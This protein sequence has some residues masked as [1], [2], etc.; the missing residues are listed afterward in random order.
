MTKHDE[1]QKKII[2][3]KN[4][5]ELIYYRHFITSYMDSGNEKTGE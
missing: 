4:Q 5:Q 1:E 2:K 3:W